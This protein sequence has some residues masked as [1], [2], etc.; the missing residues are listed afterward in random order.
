LKTSLFFEQ[1]SYASNVS[2]QDSGSEQS[3]SEL[4]AKAGVGL[5]QARRAEPETR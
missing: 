5:R 4:R 1:N 3:V 2:D